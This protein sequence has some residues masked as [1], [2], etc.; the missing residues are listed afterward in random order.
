[1]VGTMGK[2]RAAQPPI[3]TQAEPSMR[4]RFAENLRELAKDRQAHEI[5][6]RAGVT[7]D[8][9]LKWLRGE[10]LPDLDKWPALARAIGLKDYR[11]LLPKE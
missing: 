2:K 1:M 5:A 8:A 4:E 3:E 11:K 6:S 9:V 7:T 10:T